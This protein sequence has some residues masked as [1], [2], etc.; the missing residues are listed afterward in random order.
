MTDPPVSPLDNR[1]SSIEAELAAVV[2]AIQV[3]TMMV[4]VQSKSAEELMSLVEEA[5]AA[6]PLHETQFS[7]Q[8][9]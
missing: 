1:L 9:Q 2:I 5:T 6:F 8:I 4:Q 7:S 3:L